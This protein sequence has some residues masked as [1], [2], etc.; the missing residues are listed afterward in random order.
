MSKTILYC[1]E[2]Q[3]ILILW[4]CI[5]ILKDLV[6]KEVAVMFGDSFCATLVEMFVLLYNHCECFLLP[7]ELVLGIRKPIF[8]S[9][10]ESLCTI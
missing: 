4:K 1:L 3:Q 8:S 7:V 9:F 2:M 5:E 6:R 10:Q